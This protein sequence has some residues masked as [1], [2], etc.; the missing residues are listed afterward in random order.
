ML[1]EGV[2]CAAES[3]ARS[4]LKIDGKT[5]LVVSTSDAV[6]DNKSSLDLDGAVRGDQPLSTRT[7][8]YKN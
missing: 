5:R 2:G 6:V 1:F 3:D 7:H 8:L 4:D